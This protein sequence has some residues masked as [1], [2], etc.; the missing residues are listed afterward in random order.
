MRSAV[1]ILYYCVCNNDAIIG[2]DICT[3]NIIVRYYPVTFAQVHNY[4][5][6]KTETPTKSMRNHY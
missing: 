6:H 5:Q 2:L 3:L 1:C 4:T